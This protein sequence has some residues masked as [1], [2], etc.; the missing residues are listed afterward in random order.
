MSTERI[1]ILHVID[2]LRTGEAETLLINTVSEL[3][4]YDHVVVA[5]KQT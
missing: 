1:K 5:Y 2:S 4:E 3:T